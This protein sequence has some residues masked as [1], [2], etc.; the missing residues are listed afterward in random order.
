MRY[1][2]TPRRHA[3]RAVHAQQTTSLPSR[4]RHTHRTTWVLLATRS[5]G[6]FSRKAQTSKDSHEISFFVPFR[7][8]RWTKN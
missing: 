8:S 1:S 3:D 2:A 7:A 5:I 6:G 4:I